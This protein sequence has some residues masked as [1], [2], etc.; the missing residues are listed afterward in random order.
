MRIMNKKWT[1][2]GHLYADIIQIN[3]Q[4]HTG[5]PGITVVRTDKGQG[6]GV[7]LGTFA[8]VG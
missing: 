1:W 7:K 5:N 3:S 6:G 2:A 4:M 8:R